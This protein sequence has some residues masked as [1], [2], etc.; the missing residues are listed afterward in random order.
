MQQMSIK[1]HFCDRKLLN[2][3]DAWMLV[4]HAVYLL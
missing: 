3:L 2:S 4:H 1:V